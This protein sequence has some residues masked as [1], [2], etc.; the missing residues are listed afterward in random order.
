MDEFSIID[1]ACT[2]KSM[3][4]P[5]VSIVIPC[6]RQGHLLAMA[7][8]SALA[9]S[10][11]D[12]EVIVVNDGSDD[13]TNEVAQSYGNRIRYLVKANGGLSSARNAGIQIA[14]GDCFL[15]LD[16]DDLLHT[17][18]L[19]HAVKAIVGKDDWLCLM[20]YR[21]FWGN[22]VDDVESEFLPDSGFDIAHTTLLKNAAPPNAYM[23]SAAMVR[24]VGGFDES[25][26]SCEHSDWDLWL[27]IVMAGAE[28][29]KVPIIG[30]LYRRYAGSM[31]TNR[32][33]MDQT[34]AEV[35]WRAYKMARAMPDMLK[36][37]NLDRNR[38]CAEQRIALRKELYDV[39]F[40]L[41]NKSMYKEGARYYWRAFL[42]TGYPPKALLGILKL[43]LHRFMRFRK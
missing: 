31:S 37:H 32:L 17:D 33:R 35:L 9:Q 43:L 13:N 19:S 26:M 24:S 30:A 3:K 16:A 36:R 25:L 12:V 2:L 6:Y 29:V 20:G 41:R 38:I 27:R 23:C 28:L 8:E 5:T 14:S 22:C 42:W 21:V 34:R 10:Y 1:I 40:D 11:S 18:A 15:F 4:Q 39:A 7:V